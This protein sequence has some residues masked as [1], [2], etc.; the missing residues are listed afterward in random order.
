MLESAL[1]LHEVWVTCV[2]WCL[3]TWGKYHLFMYDQLQVYLDFVIQAPA[4]ARIQQLEAENMQLRQAASKRSHALAQARQF[5]DS[6]LQ[7]SS[8]RLHD[9]PDNQQ[10]GATTSPARPVQADPG[11]KQ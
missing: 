4:H 9:L 6:N 10:N 2:W 11:A 3:I 1:V 7:R 8:T 5:I